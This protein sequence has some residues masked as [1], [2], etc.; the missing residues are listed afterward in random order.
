VIP[1]EITAQIS[2]CARTRPDDL[3]RAAALV[4][5]A[6][7]GMAWPQARGAILSA[8]P[9]AE[10]REEMARLLERWQAQAPA[11]P[12]QA[13]AYALAAAAETAAAMRAEQSLSLVWTG[14]R[15]DGP[16]LRNTAQALQ[17]VIGAAQRELLLVS[18]AV[19]M[20][21]QIAQALVE[22]AGR[23]V[24]IRIVLETQAESHGRIDYDTVGAL[25][26]AVAACAQL[27]VWPAHKRER[28][29]TGTLGALHAKCAV[30]DRKLLFISSA[31]LT[32]HAL[33]INME[34]GVMINGGRLPSDVT[35]QYMRLIENG[36][37]EPVRS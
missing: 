2:Q 5:E 14:P 10:F 34:L 15:V 20:V 35:T 22:A 1:R 3:V 7:A 11:V 6:T 36:I 9:H 28:D 32:G 8:L 27:Y 13:L 30:A 33:T 31:N 26:R 21:P 17:Q 16:A 25:S 19:Y 24:A 18:F 12:R 29:L 23:G 4:L 37:L